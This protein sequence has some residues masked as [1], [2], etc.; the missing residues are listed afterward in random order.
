MW[1]CT[2]WPDCN[3][4][5]NI[6][7]SPATDGPVAPLA[8]IRSGTPGAYAQIML[9]RE[10]SVL[11]L[12]R[13]AMLPLVVGTTLI[14]MN[15]VFLASLQLGV[16][17]AALVGGLVGLGCMYVLFRLP[18]E[19]LVWTKGVEG[20]QKAAAFI[21][22][23]LDAGF[24]ALFNR[25]IPGSQGDIDAIVIGPTGVFTIETKNWKGRVEVRND[26]LFVGDINRTWVVAQVYREA[27]AVQVTLGDELTAHRVTVT[28]I[29]CAIGGAKFGGGIAGGVH[30]LDGKHLARTIVERPTVFDDE[31]V[32]GIARLADQRLR[33]AFEWEP[34]SS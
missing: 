9:E 22:P 33:L 18:A 11:R 34:K 24:V 7:P 28:P 5:I 30:V 27:L 32:Q 17:I 26:R 4:A 1:G 14:L 15:V 8:P 21:E 23:L 3:G 16:P 10:R 19:S 20:E 29:L 2:R 25:K 31:Q 6:D 12:K 13:R